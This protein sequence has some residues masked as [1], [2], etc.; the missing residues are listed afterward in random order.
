MC[1]EMRLAGTSGECAVLILIC[2]TCHP[3]M[4]IVNGSFPAMLPGPQEQKNV[5]RIW[6]SNL[7]VSLGA[8]EVCCR[9]LS[10]VQLAVDFD[11]TTSC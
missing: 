2:D 10:C 3:E 1:D 4:I 5:E 7:E 9:V 6:L 11:E 8:M